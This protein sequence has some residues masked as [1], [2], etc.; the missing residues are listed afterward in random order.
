MPSFPSLHWYSLAQTISSPR[1]PVSSTSRSTHP[2]CSTYWCHRP[3]SSGQAC[4]QA[5]T[6]TDLTGTTQLRRPGGKS[7]KYWV[8]ASGNCISVK[9]FVPWTLVCMCDTEY[10]SLSKNSLF[11]HNYPQSPDIHVQTVSTL[12]SNWYFI[13]LWLFGGRVMWRVLSWFIV[14]AVG[15]AYSCHWPGA[16]GMQM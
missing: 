16:W 8:G 3:P 2:W 9:G 13:C 11:L 6:D 14:L 10:T 5:G 4:C 7:T 1:R 12:S 15:S